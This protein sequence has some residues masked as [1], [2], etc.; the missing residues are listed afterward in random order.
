[1]NDASRFSVVLNEAKAA[2]LKKL[3]ELFITVLRDALLAIGVNP[4]VA[5]CYIVELGAITYAKNTDRKKTAQLNKNTES[6]W[7]A[8]RNYS[9]DIELSLCANNTVYN[10]SGVDETLVPMRKM[11]ELLANYGLPVRK[12]RALDIDVRLAMLFS[13]FWFLLML[14]TI[15]AGRTPQAVTAA[16]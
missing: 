10:T 1:M 3:P 2:K 7:W 9:S 13:G 5:D 4:E 11:L 6:A 15:A 14:Q 16:S 12:F 8:L